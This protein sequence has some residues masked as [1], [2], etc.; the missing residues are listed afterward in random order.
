MNIY[1]INILYIVLSVRPQNTEM[2]KKHGNEIFSINLFLRQSVGQA[3]K[4]SEMKYENVIFPSPNLDRRYFFSVY[5]PL[6]CEHLYYNF[7]VRRT[8]I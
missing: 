7:F 4:G 5:F 1:S 6:I 3:T 2:K 8:V